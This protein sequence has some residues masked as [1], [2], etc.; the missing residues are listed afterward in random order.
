[1]IAQDARGRA[2]AR[3]AARA[4]LPSRGTLPGCDE[5]RYARGATGRARLHLR[6]HASCTSGSSPPGRGGTPM[7]ATAHLLRSSTF[8]A[9]PLALLLVAAACSSSDSGEGDSSDDEGDVSD[10]GSDDG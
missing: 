8:L 6:G 3:G 10:D 2:F 1:M 9:I 5:R 4:G 7:R